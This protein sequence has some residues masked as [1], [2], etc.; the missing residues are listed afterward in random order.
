MPDLRDELGLAAHAAGFLT[1]LP[2]PQTLD[3]APELTGR[4]A[5]WFVPV[6]LALGGLA[7][8]VWLLARDLGLPPFAAA[9]LA[10]GAL[11]VLT[12][13]LHEDGLADCADGLG[14]RVARERALEI[15]RD[16][17]IGSYG[18]LALVL[19]LMLRV[20]C[21]A[22]LGPLPGLLALMLAA[23]IGR[24]GIVAGLALM[25]YARPQGLATG[26]ATDL[27]SLALALLTAGLAAVAL[28]G[29]AG[30][31][32]LLL[33]SAAWLWFA[34]VLRRRLGGYTGD[35]LGALAQ[36][37]EMAALAACAAVWA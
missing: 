5:R 25:P 19:S 28:G 14:G 36:L 34:N 22:A 16:S 2:V 23:G 7:G 15:M 3:Y 10:V 17:R 8:L 26:A 30:L 32:A 6:G 1:R 13:G 33:A 12:G 11:V 20:A 18:A 31:V 4:S 29:A 24:A 35:G 9:V 37:T 27:R 21:L